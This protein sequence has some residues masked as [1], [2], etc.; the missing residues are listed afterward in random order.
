MM[1]A[2]PCVHGAQNRFGLMDSD[3]GAIGQDP[4]LVVGDHRSDLNDIIPGRI[5]TSH[6][7]IDPDKIIGRLGHLSVSILSGILG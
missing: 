1:L 2:I 5:Q 6:F 3:H 4:E 7:Q